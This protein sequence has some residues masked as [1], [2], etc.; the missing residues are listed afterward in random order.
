[1]IY[2][3]YPWENWWMHYRPRSKREWWDKR[4][5]CKMLFKQRHKTQKEAKT[6]RTKRKVKIMTKT[7]R[8]HIHFTHTVKKLVT[9]KESVGG[10]QMSSARSVVRLGTWRGSADHNNIKVKQ[11]LLLNNFKRSSCLLQHVLW[12]A[13]ALVTLGLLILVAHTIWLM[14]RNSTK[15]LFPK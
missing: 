10:D 1:M 15:L 13:T 3:V 7:R 11:M 12:Q 6:K 5:L 4:N 2:Q 14:T 8:K 9:R